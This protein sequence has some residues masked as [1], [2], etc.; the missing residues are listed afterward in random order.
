[1]RSSALFAQF[2]DDLNSLLASI[3]S[4]VCDLDREVKYPQ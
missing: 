4:A 1:M 2:S 3:T